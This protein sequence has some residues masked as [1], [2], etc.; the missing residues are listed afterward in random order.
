VQYRGPIAPDEVSNTFARYD[1]FV[2]PTQGENFGHVI[3][4]ALRAGTPVLL[5][6]RT[7]WYP[8][9]AGALIVLSLDKVVSWR[10]AIE[11]AARRTPQ[12]QENLRLVAHEYA[13]RYIA[14]DISLKANFEMFNSFMVF[15]KYKE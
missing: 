9:N 2:F 4:E 5:S 3:F 1:L 11:N 15:P 8:D 12:E 6:D 13:S 14:G 10:M 7:P